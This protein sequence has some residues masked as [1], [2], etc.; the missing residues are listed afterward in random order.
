[1]PK[2]KSKV[3]GSTERKKF[4]HCTPFCNKR[5]TQQ[6][7]RNHYK[8]LRPEQFDA[9]QYSESAVSDNSIFSEKVS[10]DSDTLQAMEGPGLLPT[11]ASSS[12]FN[13]AT[14]QIGYDESGEDEEPELVEGDVNFKG[15]SQTFGRDEGGAADKEHLI[16]TRSVG[17]ESEDGSG[18]PEGEALEDDYGQWSDQGSEFDEWKAYHEDDEAA[19]LQSDEER[20]HE[21]EDILGPEQH[22]ELWKS[23]Q[24]LTF[25]SHTF[26]II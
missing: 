26:L 5:L 2:K 14:S 1:M 23:R 3:K 16:R 6:A 15:F 22:A 24:Y 25:C 7:R 4:C 12:G 20:L 8:R 9:V 10:S 19:A 18:E 17:E 11:L 21:F 13:S